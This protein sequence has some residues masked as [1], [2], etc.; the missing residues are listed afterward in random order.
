[1][2]LSITL[3]TDGYI[4]IV[5]VICL[6]VGDG[7]L[8]VSSHS[9]KTLEKWIETKAWHDPHV[10]KLESAYGSLQLISLI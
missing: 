5:Y 4:I 9:Q 7:L 1:M 2:K 6:Y 8:I 3:T 10:T